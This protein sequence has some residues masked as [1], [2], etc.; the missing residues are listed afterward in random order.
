MS[1]AVVSA[2]LEPGTGGM[3]VEPLDVQAGCL[4]GGVEL[5]RTTP[6]VLATRGLSKD[7]GPIRVVA[8]VSLNFHAGSIHALLGENGAGKSTLIKMVAGV[9][10]PSDGTVEIAGEPVRFRSVKEGQAAGIVALPQEL[11]L[12]PTIGAA[13]NIFLG[14]RR[15]GPPG[16]VS[17]G[18]LTADATEQLALL[19]QTFNVNTPVAEL[20]AVQQ[21]MVALARALARDARVLVLDEPT[22]ALTDTETEQLFTVLRSLRDQGTA[23]IY[24]SHRLE[25]VFALAD[26]ATV[27]RNGQHVWTKSMEQT[28]HDDVVAAMIG[29]ERDEEFPQRA[30]TSG[31]P[32]LRV[33]NLHG[34]TLRGVSLEARSGRVLG[35]AGLAGAGRTELLR[36]IAG[37]ER[38]QGGTIELD[39]RDITRDSVAQSMAAGVALVPEERR[40]Q[41][42]VMNASIATNIGLGSLK[43][44][45]GGGIMRPRRERELALQQA[46]ELQIRATSVTQDVSE[47]SGGNQQKVVLAKYLARKPRVLLLDEPTRGIDV[48]TK[49]EI[50]Q[51]IRR[52]TAEGVAV[53]VVSSE[54]SEL[55]GLADDIAVL[56]QGRLSDIVDAAGT[57]QQTIL[58]LCYGRL[59]A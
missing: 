2:T 56:H 50:Y 6:P 23:I 21:T 29:R 8:D 3:I 48:G 12:V 19:G 14:M 16:L 36:L 52:L 1:S 27:L 18:R 10:H 59:D 34:W 28:Q 44:L 38:P 51:L 39:G 53:V 57:D 55:L 32:V 43:S 15:P 25:E 47:L 4:A 7:Y 41:G 31:E 9:V 37:V 46:E 45:S 26:T 54:I 17:R 58:H 49:S 22:A 20:S 11:M 42:L 5:S 30:A 35:I 33:E 24:V 13:E 40:R